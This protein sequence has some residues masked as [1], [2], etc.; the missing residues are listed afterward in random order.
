MSLEIRLRTMPRPT[1]PM[2]PYALTFSIL[3]ILWIVVFVP[4]QITSYGSECGEL[5]VLAGTNQPNFVAQ[6]VRTMDPGPQTTLTRLLLVTCIVLVLLSIV[7][8]CVS[9]GSWQRLYTAPK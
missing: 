7:P 9:E 8:G 2:G 5:Q 6:C 4:T 1:H 3:W